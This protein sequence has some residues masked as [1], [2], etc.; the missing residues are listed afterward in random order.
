MGI[1]EACRVGQ[2]VKNLL[3][4]VFQHTKRDL[5]VNLDQERHNSLVHCGRTKV[6]LSQPMVSTPFSK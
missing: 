5:L 2:E 3:R 1:K 6:F 4:V